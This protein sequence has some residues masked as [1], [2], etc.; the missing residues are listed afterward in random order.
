M[1]WENAKHSLSEIQVLAD[2]ECH[3]IKE[4]RRGSCR[5]R[6]GIRNRLHA[7]SRNYFI[8]TWPAFGQWRLSCYQG[9]IHRAQHYSCRGGLY[10]HILWRSCIPN[11]LFVFGRSELLI[12]A[13]FQKGSPG[14][15]N[16]D[17]I[18]R[19][20]WTF[21]GILHKFF[22]LWWRVTCP[23][24]RTNSIFFSLPLQPV[25]GPIDSG[26]AGS[27]GLFHVRQN[28]QDGGTQVDNCQWHYAIIV[29]ITAAVII[30]ISLGF[31]ADRRDLVRRLPR[32]HFINK[33]IKA[34]CQSGLGIYCQVYHQRLTIVEPLAISRPALSYA[35]QSKL[36]IGSTF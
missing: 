12:D 2:T 3:K 18:K 27:R 11:N 24:Y 35:A 8:R 19:L 34:A 31:P 4:T 7:S 20:A 16:K 9:D 33:T 25:H 29:G 32:T 23:S 22:M 28:K 1:L 13:L 6:A 10:V 14:M 5:I 21:A 36:W 30:A 26:S 17:R 15:H